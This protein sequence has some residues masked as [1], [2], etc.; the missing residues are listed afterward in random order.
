MARFDKPVGILLLLWPTWWALWLA[1]EGLP[2]WPRL[3]VFTL[4]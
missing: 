1:A 4:G 2:D 3:L